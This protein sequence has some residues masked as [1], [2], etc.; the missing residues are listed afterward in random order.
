MSIQPVLWWGTAVLSTL[1]AVWAL[2]HTL[3]SLGL[4]SFS[5]RQ[6]HS[7]GR[8]TDSKVLLAAAIEIL[9][10]LWG[11]VILACYTGHPR[12]ETELDLASN[13]S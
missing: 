9:E 6:S 5:R 12:A 8:H 11:R 3:S 2:S 7:G 1:L 10:S 13:E 4:E